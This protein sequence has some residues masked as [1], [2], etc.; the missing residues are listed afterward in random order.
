MLSQNLMCDMG[1]TGFDM[2]EKESVKRAVVVG[3]FKTCQSDKR[4]Q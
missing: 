4:K 3:N 1:A 2:E